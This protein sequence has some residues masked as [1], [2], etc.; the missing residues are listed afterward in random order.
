LSRKQKPHRKTLPVEPEGLSLRQQLLAALCIVAV[1]LTIYANS[2]S[3]PLV[4]DAKDYILIHVAKRP[5]WPPWSAM[6]DT[7][8]PVAVLSFVANY[9]LHGPEVWGYHAVNLAIHLA[10]AWVLFDLVRRTLSLPP[11]SPRYGKAA[12]PLALTVALLWMVHPLQ[13]QSVTYIYQRF[14]SLMGL[15]FLLSIY[16]LLRGATSG[17]PGWWYGASIASCLLAMGSKEVAATLPLVLVWYDRVFLAPSWRDLLKRRWGLYAALGGT[18]VFAAAL[19]LSS[20]Q[21]YRGGGVL[22]VDQTSPWQYALT[23]PGVLLHYLRLSIWPQGQ[24]LDYGWPVTRSAAEA[25]LPAIL[26]L[27]LL[28][29][30][31]WC[32]VRRPAW[33]FIFGCF[34]LILAPTSSFF[35]IRDPAFEHRMY[36]PLAA[37]VIA[38]VLGSYEIARH[39]A[40]KR[41]ITPSRRKAAYAVAV[42]AAVIALGT[43]TVL[44][45]RVYRSEVALWRDVVQKAPR[46][47]RGHNSLGAALDQLGQVDAAVRCFR[48]AL[49]LRP[50]YPR[51]HYNLAT[52]LTQSDP[53]AAIHHYRRALE[54]HPHNAK[55]HSNLGAVLAQ[56][57]D[58]NG[59]IDHLQTALEINPESAEAH[60]NLGRVLAA[61]K[62]EQAADH[63]RAAL[64][65]NPDYPDAHNNLAVVLERLGRME[66]SA[67]HYRRAI[68][69]N[70]EFAGAHFNL[71]RVL[72]GSRPEVAAGHYAAALRIQPQFAEAH[73][74]LGTILARAG[75]F[76]EAIYHYRMALQIRPDYARA[77]DNL[78]LLQKMQ[79][80]SAAQTSQ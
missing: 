68:E 11:T 44:R 6:G 56:T 43:A 75:R 27:G 19:V 57:V 4:F 34:F 31:A 25:V 42:L 63:L 80:D 79:R 49:R 78:S 46:N 40:L 35:P 72:A 33:G 1:G 10:A 77:R 74:G 67:E 3:A 53:E 64:R 73:N 30:T 23:Q 52:A 71:G 76:D 21:L 61:S 48:Q 22:F 39:P 69:L 5:L 16:C 47:P 38:I 60:N 54:D 29:A 17:R 70:P 59:A 9:R 7:N 36:L 37:V 20:M 55:A 14:E 65:I 50:D 45:N 2:F 51:A 32:V 15:F 24:C 26:L 66:E 62:P 18:L 28:A 8:R 41:W 58:V 12:W 13:T